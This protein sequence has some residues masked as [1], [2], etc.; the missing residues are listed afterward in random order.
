MSEPTPHRPP[1]AQ[2]G[3]WIIDLGPV[4]LFVL[5]FV[6]LQRFPAY[7]DNAVYIATGVFVVAIIAAMIY[8]QIT[9]GRIPPAL[10]VTG[11]IITAFGVLTI[12]LHNE[13]FIKVKNTIENGFFAVAIAGSLL[14]GQNALRLVF[15]HALNMS[16]GAWTIYAWRW[17][18][19]FATLAIVNEI[20]RYTLT[21]AGWI[22]WHF[23]ILF[24]LTVVFVL[25]NL[26]FIMKHHIEDEPTSS[27]TPN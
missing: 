18:A 7:K 9:R 11:V 21:T 22:T 8:S 23:P 3:Q 12:A 26:P 25:A 20:M 15:G 19:L 1:H 2:P 17:A 4:L 16:E 10:I 14:M 27:P 13:T 6:L 24:G 5:S